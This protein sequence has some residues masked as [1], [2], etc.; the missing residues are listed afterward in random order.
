MT[1]FGTIKSYDSDRGRGKITSEKEGTVLRFEQSALP[2]KDDLPKEAERYSFEEG[3]DAG[4]NTCAV[5]LH[6]VT[7]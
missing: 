6:R 2:Y 1:S 3:K 4:G 7:A 5:S